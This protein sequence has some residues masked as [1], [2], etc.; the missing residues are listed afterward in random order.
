MAE[1]KKKEEEKKLARN[2]TL[3]STTNKT[4]LMVQSFLSQINKFI[5]NTN[6]TREIARAATKVTLRNY[7]TKL[8]T[9]QRY[10][11]PQPLW[12]PSLIIRKS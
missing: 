12:I 4:L 7:V 11:L 5:P 2:W 6:T 1:K 9:E 10:R 3:T 8:K